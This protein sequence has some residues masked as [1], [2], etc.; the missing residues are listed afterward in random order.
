[1]E[2]RKVVILQA[3]PLSATRVQTEPKAAFLLRLEAPK[4]TTNAS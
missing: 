1:M 3:A 4:R 2:R